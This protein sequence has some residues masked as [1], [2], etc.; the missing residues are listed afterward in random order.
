MNYI[1]SLTKDV[2]ISPKNSIKNVYQPGFETTTEGAL[3]TELGLNNPEYTVTQINNWDFKKIK[4][5][6]TLPAWIDTTTMIDWMPDNPLQLLK[7]NDQAVKNSYETYLNNPSDENFIRFKRTVW[8]TLT[9]GQKHPGEHGYFDFKESYNT[10]RWMSSAYMQH[11]IRYRGGNYGPFN[12]TV[13]GKPS[14]SS[15][16]SVMDPMWSAGDIARRSLDNGSE[17]AQLPTRNEIR[18]TWLYL[19]WIGNYGKSLNFE[20]QYIADAL[21]SRGFDHLSTAVILKSMVNRPANCLAIYDDIRSITRFVKQNSGTYDKSVDFALT[22]VLNKLN[23][24]YST[25]SVYGD[26]KKYSLEAIQTSKKY[27]EEKGGTS[28]SDLLNKLNQINDL[29]SRM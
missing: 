23:N 4:I 9:E 26:D 27:I 13:D 20:S 2:K 25:M 8:N 14:E 6:M 3:A 22:F 19:G 15:Y 12:I 7:K 28:K 29:V 5:P 1:K 17:A 16:E 24:S 11:V 18:S 10:M 21:T